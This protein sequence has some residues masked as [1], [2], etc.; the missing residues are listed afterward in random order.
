[1]STVVPPTWCDLYV[2]R[3]SIHNFIGRRHV[4][5]KSP[6]SRKLTARKST[7]GGSRKNAL[8]SGQDNLSPPSHPKLELVT[9]MPDK[10]IKTEPV[11]VEYENFVKVE[12]SDNDGDYYFVP[13]GS[14]LDSDDSFNQNVKDKKRKQRTNIKT[15][16]SKV[17]LPFEK[18]SKI[19][20]FLYY[21]LERRFGNNY[22]FF[23]HHN[24]ILANRASG[25]MLLYALFHPQ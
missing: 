5:S 15:E 24:P 11:H 17:S 21:M 19:F 13:Q 7:A 18:Y 2:Y 20:S 14:D 25:I 9:I 23:R 6:T 3:F 1:M 10:D 8:S 16:I 22:S 12:K 4:A